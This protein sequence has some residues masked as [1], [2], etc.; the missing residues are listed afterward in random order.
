MHDDRRRV[1]SRSGERCG[2]E[3]TVERYVHR[4][5]GIMVWEAIADGRLI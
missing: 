3:F 2:V 1:T 5:V 4:I